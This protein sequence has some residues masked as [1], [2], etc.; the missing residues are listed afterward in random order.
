MKSAPRLLFVT[1]C[2]LV[3]AGIWPVLRLVNR[4]HPFILGL[5]LFVFYMLLLNFAVAVFLVIAFRKLE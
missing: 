2:L 1:A 5:P 4:I 3:I